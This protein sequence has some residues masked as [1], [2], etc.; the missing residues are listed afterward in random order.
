MKRDLAALTE[1]EFDVAVIGCGIF[2]ACAAWDAAQR[3]L[4]VA[5]IERDDFA[6]WTSADDK[7]SAACRLTNATG[8]PMCLS[9]SSI[10]ASS[11]RSVIRYVSSI[12]TLGNIA[13][14]STKFLREYDKQ[15]VAPD[16]AR[17]R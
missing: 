11:F 16:S 1:R 9:R 7:W 13:R 14:S 5:L 17:T 3:G 15:T 2:G 10:W 12:A 4:S 6:S 8:G